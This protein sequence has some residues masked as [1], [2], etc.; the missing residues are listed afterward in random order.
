MKQTFTRA[1]LYLGGEMGVRRSDCRMIEIETG[2]KYAQYTDAIKVTWL[3]KG[4]RKT[5]ST[6]LTYDPFVLVMPTCKAIDPDSVLGPASVGSSPGVTV[7]RSRYSSCDP[8]WRSDFMA[9][10]DKAD[11]LF[12]VEGDPKYIYPEVAEDFGPVLLPD[13]MPSET[14]RAFAREMGTEHVLDAYV[15][16]LKKGQTP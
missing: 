11:A 3:A 4:K 9:R 13:G 6:M 14:T 16:N 1:T 5:R 12:L 7:R 10:V 2:Q 8:R 15:A